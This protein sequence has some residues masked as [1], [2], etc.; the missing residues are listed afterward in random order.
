MLPVYVLPDS[1]TGTLLGSFAPILPMGKLQTMMVRGIQEVM[2]KACLE[3]SCDLQD[4]VLEVN[5]REI[6]A[7]ND[8]RESLGAVMPQKQGQQ[9]C[10]SSILRNL[11]C[12]ALQ[13]SK[14]RPSQA[15]S[16]FPHLTRYERLHRVWKDYCKRE[17]VE[18]TEHLT[19]REGHKCCAITANDGFSAQG[20]GR[21]WAHARS[22]AIWKALNQL[23]P[24][25]LQAFAQ[26][27][28]CY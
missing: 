23:S 26:S 27:S 1:A 9:L 8:L 15:E 17:R 2:E 10:P 19:S 21:T 14:S 22:Q 11:R 6:A 13:R 12:E 20:E 24:E 28:Q 3:P 16:P 5:T 25:L 7:L 4:L 18:A